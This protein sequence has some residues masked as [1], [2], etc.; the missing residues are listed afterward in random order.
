ML[1]YRFWTE[2]DARPAN[3]LESNRVDSIPFFD[4]GWRLWGEILHLANALVRHGFDHV[5]AVHASGGIAFRHLKGD[6]WREVI[7]A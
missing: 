6:V 7:A 2:S 4:I 3:T 5:R 1:Q